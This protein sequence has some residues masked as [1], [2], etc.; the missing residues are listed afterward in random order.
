MTFPEMFLWKVEFVHDEI[1]SPIPPCKRGAPQYIVAA[2]LREVLDV[3]PQK[4][5][6]AKLKY[7]V[8]SVTRE[9]SVDVVLP[10]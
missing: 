3:L 10:T 1:N 7:E 2:T 9:M 5:T 6:V 8:T 4:F